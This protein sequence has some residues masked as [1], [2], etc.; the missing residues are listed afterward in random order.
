VILLRVCS[1]LRALV[2]MDPPLDARPPNPSPLGLCNNTLMIKS[3]PQ[4][5]HNQDNTVVIIGEGG[6]DWISAD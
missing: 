3:T 4:P 5:N 1:A 6:R 2:N